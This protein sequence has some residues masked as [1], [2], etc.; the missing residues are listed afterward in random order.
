MRDGSTP[1]LVKTGR[2]LVDT[3]KRPTQNLGTLTEGAI[4]RM[5]G[6]MRSFFDK[7]D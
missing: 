5:A 6:G 2:V 1:K 4:S 7:N 3:V